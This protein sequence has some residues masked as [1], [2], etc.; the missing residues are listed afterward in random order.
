MSRGDRPQRQD[1]VQKAKLLD[2]GL[3]TLRRLRRSD[4]D[5][6]IALHTQLTDRER[7][8]RFFATHPAHME[9]FAAKLVQRTAKQ[10]AVGAFQNGQLIGVASY[11]AS[12]DPGE[13][14]MAVA[15]AHRDHLRG[16]ATVLLRNLAEAARRRGIRYFTAYVLAENT[17]MLK[18]LRDIGWPSTKTY[19]GPILQIRLD[20]SADGSAVDAYRG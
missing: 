17:L 14:E 12:D 10:Y 9:T 16:V 18:V 13:A 7:Y 11:V 2:G 1:P 15:V 3:V 6:V 20:L 19:Q 4:T 8:F 5:A